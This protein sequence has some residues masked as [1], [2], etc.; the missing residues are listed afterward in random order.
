LLP[1][2]R[3]GTKPERR[4]RRVRS[5]QPRRLRT[6]ERASRALSPSARSR[7]AVRIARA[8]ARARS[9]GGSSQI[10]IEPSGSRVSPGLPRRVT[11]TLCPCRTLLTTWSNCRRARVMESF[12]PSMILQLLELSSASVQ[13]VTSRPSS[14]AQRIRLLGLPHGGTE[15]CSGPSASG[16]LPR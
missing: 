9:G 7:M 10:M 12:M 6:A 13:A 3:A 11:V 2:C 1:A 8:A 14:S 16:F 4:W 5:A 15:R